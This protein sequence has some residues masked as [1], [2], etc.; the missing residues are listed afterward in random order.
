VRSLSRSGVALAC[1]CQAAV[2]H[3]AITSRDAAFVSICTDQ[4]ATAFEWQST[5]WVLIPYFP[6]IYSLRK[7][8]GASAGCV[9]I[10]KP[11]SEL[12]AAFDNITYGCYRITPFAQAASPPMAC[13]EW[14]ASDA[15]DAPL[16]SVTCAGDAP[17]NWIVFDP[18][19][20]FQFSR[21]GTDLSDAPPSGM[22]DPL[23]MS[24]GRCKVDRV[25]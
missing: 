5:R 7:I 16:T 25:S 21:L 3:A 19:G 17:Y 22:K 18:A 24:V 1:I 23:I 15:A 13:V 8:D 10:L 12:S 9:D 14:W 20:N 4:Q 6:N 11:K 2:A